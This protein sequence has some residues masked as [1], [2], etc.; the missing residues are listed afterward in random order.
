MTG[1]GHATASSKRTARDHRM[2]AL[3]ADLAALFRGLLRQGAAQWRPVSEDA[4]DH[5]GAP[6]DR[7]GSGARLRYR[8]SCRY[9]GRW[10]G[11]SGGH[12]V[13]VII[14]YRPPS[15][16]GSALGT[17]RTETRPVPVLR[18]GNS[19]GRALRER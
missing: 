1:G 3:A 18:V 4:P 11:A 2:I 15:Q 19:P 6:A 8:R 9:D 5:V 16:T 13:G 10:P 7:N 17:T 14:R 12:W